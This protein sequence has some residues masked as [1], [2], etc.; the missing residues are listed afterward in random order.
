VTVEGLNGVGKSTVVEHYMAEHPD[1]TCFYPAHPAYL[2]DTAM[3]KHALFEATPVASALY[4]L[5]ALADQLRELEANGGLAGRKFLS[6]R[7]V[8]STLAAAYAKEP[9][10]LDALSNVVAA[11][12]DQLLVPQKTIVLKADFETCRSR[13]ESRG[14][15]VEWDRDTLLAFGRKYRFYDLLAAA[16]H[17]VTFVDA[18]GTPD[19]VYAEIEALQLLS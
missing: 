16:G 14:K 17:D 8:W 6:D 18:S 12:N 7:S 15:G 10:C 9:A 5:A 2:A 11:I 3:K 1:V 19:Q 13:I 4:Y